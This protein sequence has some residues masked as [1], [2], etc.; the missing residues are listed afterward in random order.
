MSAECDICEKEDE[1]Q[2][3][4]LECTELVNMNKQISEIT[5]YDKIFKGKTSEQVNI[6]RIFQQNMTIKENYLKRD[7]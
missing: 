1:S 2:S 4:I 6:A 5:N 7:K 3:H